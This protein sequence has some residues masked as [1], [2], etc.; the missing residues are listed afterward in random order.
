MTITFLEL[1]NE[2][3]GQPWSMFDADAESIDDLESS[4]RISINKATSYLWNLY[5]W[6]FRVQT[7]NIRTRS[8][9]AEYD[10]PIGVLQKKTISGSK[11]YGIK[12]NNKF[13]EYKD[14][15][16]ELDLTDV[17]GEPTHFYIDGDKLYIYPTPDDVYTLN[18]KYLSPTYAK[19]EDEE[20]KYSFTDDSD[21][22]NVPE[23]YEGIFKNCLISLSMLY[24]IADESDEN[25]SGYQRQYEDALGVLM[26]YCKDSIVDKYIVW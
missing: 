16:E 18:L 25:Y 20:D 3:A 10:L 9:K 21:T 17:T 5:P 2:V 12:Y 11:K 23:K 19:D 24:A 13:L 4:L 14:D 22:L 26:K 7:S 6:Y 15:Y 1:Y 8:G